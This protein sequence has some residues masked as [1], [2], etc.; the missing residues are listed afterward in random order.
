MV[1]EK[2]TFSLTAQN[3]VCILLLNYIMYV[4]AYLVRKYEVICMKHRLKRILAFAL[5]LLVL[6]SGIHSQTYAA[7]SAEPTN[8]VTDIGDNDVPGVDENSAPTTTESPAPTSPVDEKTPSGSDEP[9]DNADGAAGK[10][11]NPADDGTDGSGS[12][13]ADAYVRTPIQLQVGDVEKLEF[14]PAATLTLEEGNWE[15]FSLG[16]DGSSLSISALKT[17]MVPPVRCNGSR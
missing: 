7:S 12:G 16:Q 11:A 15:Q 2:A 6:G 8:A 9:Q 10:T 1:A 14:D 17:G 5:V 13:E 3:I 4:T